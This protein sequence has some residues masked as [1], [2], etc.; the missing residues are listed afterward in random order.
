MSLP[1]R[2]VFRHFL[3]PFLLCFVG[4]MAIWFLVDLSD[5]LR[6]FVEAHA[7]FRQVCGHCVAQLPPVILLSLAVSL[8]LARYF[9]RR[10]PLASRTPTA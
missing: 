5:N 2:H 9:S 7:T 8:L 1:D 10:R 6:D 4:F 3:Q